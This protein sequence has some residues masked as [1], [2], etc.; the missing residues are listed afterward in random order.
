MEYLK[1]VALEFEYATERLAKAK[2]EL[3]EAEKYYGEALT[4]FVDALC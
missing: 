1:L 2:A 4:A 3:A